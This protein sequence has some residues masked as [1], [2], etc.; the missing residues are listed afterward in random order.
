MTFQGKISEIC[1]F[2]VPIKKGIKLRIDIIQVRLLNELWI[3]VATRAYAEAQF[4]SPA[5]GGKNHPSSELNGRS[6]PA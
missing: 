5:T 4:N 3:E 2:R 6:L 1:V